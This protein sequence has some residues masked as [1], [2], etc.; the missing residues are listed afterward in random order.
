MTPFRHAMPVLTLTVIL[1]ASRPFSSLADE[2]AVAEK[3]V[4]AKSDKEIERLIDQLG[5]KR[6]RD[7]EQASQELWKFGKSTMPKLKEA[8]TSPDAEVR[9][10]ALELVERIEPPPITPLL[11]P[12][13]PDL[14]LTVT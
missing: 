9:R 5:S 10:R 7:R 12:P 13:I 6:F 14:I 3:A 11:I 2:I 8:A 4:P 1:V